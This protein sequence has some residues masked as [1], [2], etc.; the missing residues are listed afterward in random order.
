MAFHLLGDHEEAVDNLNRAL[1]KEPESVKF[2]MDR[3]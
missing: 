3:A 1:E 2:L